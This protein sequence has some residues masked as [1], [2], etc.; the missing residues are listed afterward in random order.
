M[1]AENLPYNFYTNVFVLEIKGGKKIA[2]ILTRRDKKS[3]GSFYS[4]KFFQR[5]Y[6]LLVEPDESEEAVGGGVVRDAC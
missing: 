1:F 3:F 6:E 2:C 5:E 4:S